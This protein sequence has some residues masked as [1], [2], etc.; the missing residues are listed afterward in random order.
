MQIGSDSHFF[1]ITDGFHLPKTDSA[2]NPKNLPENK[3]SSR[4]SRFPAE[5]EIFRRKFQNSAGKLKNLRENKFSSGK[6]KSSAGN[7]KNLLEI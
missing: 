1:C 4:K 3:F 2:G 6:S 7:L 5:R